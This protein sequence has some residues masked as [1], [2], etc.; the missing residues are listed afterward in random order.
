[1]TRE[2]DELVPVGHIIGAFGVKGQVKIF[3]LTSPRENIVNY[4][5]WLI[6]HSGTT[7]SYKVSGGR[8]GKNVIVW[9]QDIDSRELADQ[10][11]GAEIY[12]QRQQLP[13]LEEGEYYWSQLQGLDVVNKDGEHFGSI[14][15]MLETGANDVMVVLGD[16]ERLIPY[17]MGDVVKRIDLDEKKLVVDWDADF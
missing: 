7:T 17:V 10:L 3:S 2:Q 14:D 15:H 13:E 1:M 12:I 5:P 11:T 4:S 8:Q 9:L 6:K 16:R